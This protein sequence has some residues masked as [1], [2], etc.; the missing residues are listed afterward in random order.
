MESPPRPARGPRTE[1]SQRQRCPG[2]RLPAGG[3]RGRWR[4][5]GWAP[6]WALTRPR[7]EPRP[8][9]PPRELH[10]SF[11]RG[12]G[13]RPARAACAHKH[14]LARADRASPSPAGLAERDH[15]P[16]A[17]SAPARNPPERAAT[18]HE[19]PR[20]P[21]AWTSAA[22]T[23]WPPP[24]RGGLPPGD[25]PPCRAVPSASGDSPAGVRPE[26]NVSAAA[27]PRSASRR[28]ESAR[29]PLPAHRVP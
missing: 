20:L 27:S 18:D 15:T 22:G 28:P 14:S 12:K 24:A 3:L 5:R 17:P 16:P 23:G 21:D 25:S 2:P 26:R 10:R 1:R 4:C 9:C 7:G 29:K 19:A 13:T 6:P 8:R 11:V